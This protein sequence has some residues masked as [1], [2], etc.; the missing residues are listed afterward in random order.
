MLSSCQSP[1]GEQWNGNS[2]AGKKG[3]GGERKEERGGKKWPTKSAQKLRWW[4]LTAARRYLNS[5]PKITPL[6]TSD[7]RFQLNIGQ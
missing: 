1:S 3:G 4:G 6:W 5:V 7:L 2:A